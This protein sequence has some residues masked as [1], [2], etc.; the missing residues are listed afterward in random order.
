MVK[1]GN[2]LLFK[3]VYLNHLCIKRCLNKPQCFSEEFTVF[4][5]VLTY[6]VKHCE[7][8]LCNTVVNHVFIYN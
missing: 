1:S 4:H 7:Q 3:S 2:V 8:T 6:T 5:R